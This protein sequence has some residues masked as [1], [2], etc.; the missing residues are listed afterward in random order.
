MENPFKGKYKPVSSDVENVEQSD[1]SE[2]SVSFI[3]DSSYD[4]SFH[5]QMQSKP[6][7]PSLGK[8]N[9][10][11][12]G[13]KQSKKKLKPP[14]SK[15]HKLKKIKSKKTHF[16]DKIKKLESKLHKT[17]YKKTIFQKKPNF[18][19][20]KDIFWDNKHPQGLLKK[21]GSSDEENSIAALED[22][23]SFL[24][25]AATPLYE[26]SIDPLYSFLK[27]GASPFPH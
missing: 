4:L 16:I 9:Q 26:P 23:L 20:P 13:G 6:I 8:G 25:V 2:S 17:Q 24:D 15:Y 3:S 14:I 12:S 1:S 11:D 18:N 5:K 10:S 27:K 19:H 7:G 22:H 21:K